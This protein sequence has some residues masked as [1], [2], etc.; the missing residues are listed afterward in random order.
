MN[1]PTK[2]ASWPDRWHTSVKLNKTK[3]LAQ[4]QGD[5]S[6]DLHHP[7]LERINWNAV[8]LQYT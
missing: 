1:D 2:K 6:D 8:D 5:P 3:K 7:T 4:G